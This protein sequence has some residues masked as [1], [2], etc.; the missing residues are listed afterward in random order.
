MILLQL[1]QFT[2]LYFADENGIHL[3]KKKEHL[4]FW[5]EFLTACFF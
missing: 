4:T 2:K 3:E 1:K 5:L